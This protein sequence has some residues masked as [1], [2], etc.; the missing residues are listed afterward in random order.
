MALDVF[1][2]KTEFPAIRNGI[3]AQLNTSPREPFSDFLLYTLGRFDDALQF[4]Q[5]SPLHTVLVH[6]AAHSKLRKILSNLFQAVSRPGDRELLLDGINSESRLDQIDPENA[7]FQDADSAKASNR[8]YQDLL[9]RI[10]ES[11]RRAELKSR[12]KTP[13]ERNI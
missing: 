7:L 1:G 13:Q 11:E 8:N 2:E 3:I 10:G 6:A 9:K 4:N 12:D 5:K